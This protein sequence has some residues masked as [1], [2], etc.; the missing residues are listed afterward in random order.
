MNV[1]FFCPE[2]S[3]ELRLTPEVLGRTA[4]C[5]HCGETIRYPDTRAIELARTNALRAEQGRRRRSMARL[6]PAWIVSL[7]IHALLVLMFAGIT[8]Q[9]V[10]QPTGV[11]AELGELPAGDLDRS[12]EMPLGV[13][14]SIPVAP[15]QRVDAVPRM[16][17]IPGT[18][19][20]GS[21]V[22]PASVSRGLPTGER[23][24]VPG[25]GGKG[26]FRG[27]LKGLRRRG[28]D[29]VFVFDSTGSMGPVIQEVTRRIDAMMDT[30]FELVPSAQIGLVTYRDRGSLEKYVTRFSPLTGDRQRVRTWLGTIDADGGGDIPEA[31]LDGLTLAMDAKRNPWRPGA[32]K[33]IVL[34]GDA[35][36]HN[37]PARRDQRKCERVAAAFRQR[38]GLVSA[39]H[40]H[41]SG[42]GPGSEDRRV[43]RA[44]EG[45]TR[46][47]G[48]ETVPMGNEAE[49]VHHLL[50]LV[51]GS[52][53]RS[54][55]VGEYE[56]RLRRYDDRER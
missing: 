43:R 47:G 37:G 22:S 41:A 10:V 46:A 44:F 24:T 1:Q 36:P 28:L 54:N 17:T 38:G 12:G 6:V 2:C 25:G 3:R 8:W 18:G 15:I 45:I 9:V 26:S 5:H 27:L 4:P 21:L 49:I 14:A 35:P 31:V 16:P 50:A 33:I 48:G 20:S 53:W 19:D 34:F 51:F 7:A 29:V 52:R 11:G 40:V 23:I 42:L 55:I 30:L 13:D 32:R 39:V 56:K